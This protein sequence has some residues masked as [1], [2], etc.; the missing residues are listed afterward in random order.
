MRGLY[1]LKNTTMPKVQLSPLHNK[2]AQNEAV[3][4]P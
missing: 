3:G 1:G 4:E 2:R